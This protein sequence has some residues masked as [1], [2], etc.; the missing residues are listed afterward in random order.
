MLALSTYA[1]A[2]DERLWLVFGLFALFDP[3]LEPIEAIRG[4]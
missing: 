4:L 2:T 3:S 1:T